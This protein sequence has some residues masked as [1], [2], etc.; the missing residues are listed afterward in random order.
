MNIK[1]IDDRAFSELWN[2]EDISTTE[3]A[4]IL[5]LCTDTVRAHA[6]RLGLPAKVT[7]GNGRRKSDPTPEEILERAEEVRSRWTPGERKRRCVVKTV[8][9]WRP[10]VVES[11]G[12]SY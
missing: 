10:P 11:A 7:P 12:F 5:K 2:D 1:P 9:R 4:N 6:A 3:I 8:T